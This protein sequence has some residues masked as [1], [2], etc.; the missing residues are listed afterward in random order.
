MFYKIT[1]LKTI[2][3][4]KLSQVAGVYQQDFFSY[5]SFLIIYME[6]S[7]ITTKMQVLM[8]VVFGFRNKVKLISLSLRHTSL[9]RP[10][11][12][13]FYANIQKFKRWILLR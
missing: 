7:L 12:D 6:V 2:I 4:N 9:L 10:P 3:Y 13:M 8:N 1:L 5:L 11:Y